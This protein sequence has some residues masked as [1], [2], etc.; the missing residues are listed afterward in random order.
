MRETCDSWPEWLFCVPRIWRSN[1]VNPY[2]PLR[3]PLGVSPPPRET[4]YKNLPQLPGFPEPTISLPATDPSRGSHS[5]ILPSRKSKAHGPA[6]PSL[7]KPIAITS[8]LALASAVTSALPPRNSTTVV[9][10]TAAWPCKSSH[11]HRDGCIPV[12]SCLTTGS[13]KWQWKHHT[14]RSP[15]AAGSVPARGPRHRRS[16]GERPRS[17]SPGLLPRPRPLPGVSVVSAPSPQRAQSIPQPSPR[18]PSPDPPSTI[19]STSTVLVPTTISGSRVISTLESHLD[20][21]WA[22]FHPHS[23]LHSHQ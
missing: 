22:C 19:T 15:D 20:T 23:H 17:L 8:L 2:G 18:L 11:L 5:F 10:A 9:T 3:S 1:T 4:E 6:S 14:R 13:T 12:L 16:L 7:M 21:H